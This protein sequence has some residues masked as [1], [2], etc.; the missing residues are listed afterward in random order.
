MGQYFF[1]NTNTINNRPDINA[2]L[3][4][5][6]KSFKGFLRAENLNTLSFEGG[7]IGFTKRNL[8]ANDYVAPGLMIR[9]G[10]WWN[11]IN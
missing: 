4:F 5:R 6:I 2:F 8:M 9:F 3:H 10:V 11:F 1:Q 7:N